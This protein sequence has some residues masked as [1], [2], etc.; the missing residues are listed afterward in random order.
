MYWYSYRLIT[1]TDDRLYKLNVLVQPP[2]DYH[3][4]LYKLNL[5][6]N[7]PVDYLIRLCTS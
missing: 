6:V 4:R 2:D 3:D 1:L 7:T 5:L